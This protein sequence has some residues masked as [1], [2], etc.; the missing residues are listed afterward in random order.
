M[1]LVYTESW[2]G[3]EWSSVTEHLTTNGAGGGRIMLMN[4]IQNLLFVH[5]NEDKRN[6]LL[7]KQGLPLLEIYLETHTL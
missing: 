7:P 2:N 3:G 1:Y 5:F 6:T 4:S